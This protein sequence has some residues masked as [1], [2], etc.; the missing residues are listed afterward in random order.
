MKFKR[1]EAHPDTL[2]CMNNLAASYLA[3]DKLD[4]ALPLFEL[5]LKLKKTQLG[6]DHPETLGSMNNLAS[7]YQNARKLELAVLL[8]EETLKIMKV[9]LGVD[10]PD[11]LA[12][13]SNLA[14]GYEA[15][16][17]LDLSLPLHVEAFKLISA[18]MGA[19]HPSSLG[20]MNNLAAGYQLSGKH[21]QALPLYEETL[22]LLKVQLGPDHPHTLTS[23]SN[24]ASC[25]RA[26]GKLDKAIP[27]Y[28]IAAQGSEKLRFQHEHAKLIIPGTF[29]AYEAAKQFDKAEPWRRKWL[30]H[31]KLQ[32]GAD[33]PTYAVE[34]AALGLNLLQQKKR[35]DAETMFRECL[36]IRQEKES[37][38]WTTF[39]SQVFL[40]AALRYQKKYTE[41]E[42][43]L[44]KGYEGMKQREGK[45][46]P[47]SKIRLSEALDHLIQLYSETNKP[48]EVKKWQ[49]EKDKLPDPQPAKK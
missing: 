45:I 42:P 36:V 4:L 40:G 43:L 33:H 41:A 12:C 25:Y 39:N 32:V 24:L 11:T 10:H 23:M 48:D 20:S 15:A 13:L 22:K 44:I 21:D 19:S 7:A 14:T 28:E 5:V 26:T 30:Q 3:A 35:T 31:I 29:R 46:P 37:N 9:K 17:R 8:Y 47:Q 16:G 38:N 34:L 49:A 1:G 2:D 18:K 27:L 6:S